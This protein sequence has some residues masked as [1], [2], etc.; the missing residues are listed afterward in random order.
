MLHVIA[1]F[2]LSV[3]RDAITIGRLLVHV[4]INQLCNSRSMTF[5]KTAWL[6]DYCLLQT[7]VHHDLLTLQC[8]PLGRQHKSVPSIIECDWLMGLRKSNR[9]IAQCDLTN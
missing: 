2:V 6:W 7:T 5:T 4:T 3:N 9:R 1:S 8:H